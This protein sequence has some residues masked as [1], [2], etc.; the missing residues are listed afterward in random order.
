M[1]IELLSP[2]EKLVNYFYLRRTIVLWV[3]KIQENNMKVL[4]DTKLV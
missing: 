3:Y 1:D 4:S 2:Q